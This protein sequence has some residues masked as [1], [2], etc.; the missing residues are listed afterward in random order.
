M[1][2]TNRSLGNFSEYKLGEIF[3]MA[4]KFGNCAKCGKKITSRMEKR[5]QVIKME[6]SHSLG[7]MWDDMGIYYLCSFE[8]WNKLKL[9]EELDFLSEDNI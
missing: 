5:Q 9:K 1:I 7:G 8:C 6:V 4:R 3:K 2:K